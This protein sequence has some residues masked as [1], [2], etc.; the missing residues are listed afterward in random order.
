MSLVSQ[1]ESGEGRRIVSTRSRDSESTLEHWVQDEYHLMGTTTWKTGY[2][3]RC[4]Q[5]LTRCMSLDYLLKN[6]SFLCIA[7]LYQDSCWETENIGIFS[8]L[9][10][11]NDSQV[12]VFC[13]SLF[14]FFSG[15]DSMKKNKVTWLR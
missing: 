6:T 15:S 9:P 5:P 14:I 10:K 3:W 7:C 1:L 13:F 4:T 2:Y 8:R 11:S 12:F